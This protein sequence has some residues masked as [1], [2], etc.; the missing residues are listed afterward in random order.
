MN[1][2]VNAD[3]Q[4]S[5]QFPSFPATVARQMEGYRERI[6]QRIAAARKGKGWERDDL[7]H[8]S[9][10]SGR[11]I[12]RIES[13]N[14]E[15]PRRATLEALADTLDI[16]LDELRPPDPYE[17]E[18]DFREQVDRIEEKLDYLIGRLFP[19]EPEEVAQLLERASESSPPASGQKQP[20]KPKTRATPP[21]SG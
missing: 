14:T 5:S 7:A 3:G 15:A 11:T 9:K 18:Q 1:G 12:Q 2:H 4:V 16:P 17:V 8:Y 13:G 10:V 21:S 6:G 20:S 19:A